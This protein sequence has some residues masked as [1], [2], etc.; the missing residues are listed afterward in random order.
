MRALIGLIS[1]LLTAAVVFTA[2]VFY[3]S[4]TEPAYEAKIIKATL[5]NT[6]HPVHL[7]TTKKAGSV[8][9]GHKTKNAKL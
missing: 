4:K 9:A 6:V 8:V 2:V 7:V 5:A 1:L 3:N